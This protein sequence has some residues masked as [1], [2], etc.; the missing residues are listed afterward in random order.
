MANQ[1]SAVYWL[2]ADGNTYVKAAGTNG[3]QNYGKL[4]G[5]STIAGASQISD[6]SAPAQGTTYGSGQRGGGSNDL[7]SFDQSIDATNAQI[8]NLTPSLNSGITNADNGYQSTINSLLQGK[9]N[10]DQTYNTNKTSNAQDYSGAK[11]TIHANTGATINGVDSLLGSRG[12]GGQAAGTY[13][14]LLAGRAGTEQ[15]NDAGTNFGKNE[16]ALDTNYNNFNTGYNTNTTNAALQH[17]SDIKNV[18]ANIQVQ[19]ANLL[20][21]LASLINQRT[22][23]SGGSGTAASQPYADQAKQ[24]LTSASALG[25]PK[26]IAPITPTTYTAPTLSSYTTNPTT[27]TAGG[28]A[29]TD[30]STP[31]YTTLLNRNKQLQ[32]A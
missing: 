1:P 32:A 16:Q 17:D 8:N 11:S 25:A 22:A 4:P 13:A 14:A 9:A 31:F 26:T 15:L 27:V 10:A 6:P 29:A 12:G 5:G 7:S 18:Q 24:L 30:T 19:K 21:S 3:V 23:A 28:T 20:Q 2:G